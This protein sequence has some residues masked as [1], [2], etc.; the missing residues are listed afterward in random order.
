MQVD[1]RTDS[2]PQHV[3]DCRGL[4]RHAWDYAVP[5]GP[6]RRA[7][8]AKYGQVEVVKRCDRCGTTETVLI[9]IRERTRV[10]RPKRVYDPEYLISREYTG[11]GRLSQVDAFV[12]ALARR[13]A[14]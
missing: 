8:L 10:G 13:G 2:M 5:M 7:E 9:N 14:V 4:L 11:S 3:L 6:S 1:P 12:A